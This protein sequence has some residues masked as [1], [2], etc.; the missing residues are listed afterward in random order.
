MT[1]TESAAIRELPPVREP[2]FWDGTTHSYV[3][4]DELSIDPSLK[5]HQTSTSD[6]DPVTYEVVRYS[7]LNINLEHSDLVQRL[8]VSPIT[9]LTRDFQV[10]LLTELGDLVFLGPNLQYFSNS[11]ALSIKYMLENR[12]VEPGIGPGDM[13]LSNDPYV[14]APH[15]PDTCIAAPVFIGDELFCWVANT[16]HLSDVGGSMPG[17]FCI[18]AQDAFQEPLNWPPVKLVEGG[19]LR[20]EIEEL[21]IRQ[22]RQPGAVQMDMRAAIGANEA[23]RA[24]VVALVERYGADV[25]K[26]VMNGTLDAGERLFAERLAA[27]PDG[28]WSHRAY[29]EAAVPGDRT[30]YQY[31][32]TI[33][34]QGSKL[35]VDNEGTDPQAGAINVTFAAF[36]GAVLAALTQMMV[37]DLAGAYGGAYRCVEFRPV[38]GLLN[39]CDYPAA[40]SP[41]GAL[42]TE[43]QLNAAAIVV[44]KMLA[45]GDEQCRELILGSSIPHFYAFIAAGLTKDGEEFIFPSTNGM[46]GSIGGRP[47]RDGVDVGGHWWIPDGIA[48]NC[49]D[50]EAQN[51]MLMLYRKLL[52]AGLDGS[53]RHRG[54]AGF[55]ECV[56]AYN[57]QIVQAVLHMGESFAKG[58]GLFGG[59]PGSLST[60]KVKHKTDILEQLAAGTVPASIDDVGGETEQAAFKGAPVDLLEGDVFEWISPST[61]GYGDPLMREPAAILADIVEQFLDPE[62]AQRVYGVVIR[63]GA[64]DEAAT[65]AKRLD[66]RRERLGGTEPGE[67]VAAPDGAQEVGE[68]L[69]IVDGRWWCNGA[70]LGSTEDNYRTAAVTCEVLAREIGPEFDAWDHDMA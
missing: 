49:E 2:G 62:R 45:C 54:G 22:S 30:I 50:I 12:V 31:Q 59:N 23:T 64:V 69:H 5:L 24:K 48:Y 6:I 55:R 66:V 40:V 38:P 21:F 36:S 15:Q 32:I 18:D 9:M 27:I 13:I 1:L 46:M 44:S 26:G 63:D 8:C 42:T 52:D 47:T 39:C 7:L 10:S 56:V 60:S 3:P 41:S 67:P 43:M 57:A 65:A 70:D 20:K 61:S 35:I 11:H 68:I 58:Q 33:T 53:G 25:V 17:S 19:K 4:G 34:K 28:S 37:S 16:M 14:G 51:P 29:T